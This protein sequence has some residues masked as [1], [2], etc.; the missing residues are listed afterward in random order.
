MK[1]KYLKV[2]NWLL[3]S[4]GGLLSLSLA[5]C[6]QTNE[7]DTPCA[8]GTPEASYRVKGTVV[9]EDGE[10]VAGIGVQKRY[11]DHV[12]GEAQYRYADT[13]DAEGKFNVKQ[14]LFD[15]GP[16]VV[17]PVE[18][19]DTDGEQ[20]GLYADTTVDVSFEGAHFSGGDGN[21]Y[22]GEATRE[23]EVTLHR[24]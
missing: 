11:I 1:I 17:L 6:S 18:F 14:I 15:D 22:G 20:N 5:S 12:N 8:Y 9:N 21:W 3:L 10:P 24:E 7:E 2:K 16:N 4:V 23:I 19:H 13:T